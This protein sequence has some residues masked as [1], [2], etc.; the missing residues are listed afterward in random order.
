[1]WGGL[2]SDSGESNVWEAVIFLWPSCLHWSFLTFKFSWSPCCQFV[3]S[4]CKLRCPMLIKLLL[5][6]WQTRLRWC[7]YSWISYQ[8]FWRWLTSLRCPWLYHTFRY[9]FTGEGWLRYQSRSEAVNT[10]PLDQSKTV[11]PA[12]QFPSR[13]NNTKPI[14][15][16]SLGA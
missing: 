14:S 5:L 9:S 6:S 8:A 13:Y 16:S 15:C 10:S 4:C 2:S 11:D 1:M 3:S 7:S 12:R